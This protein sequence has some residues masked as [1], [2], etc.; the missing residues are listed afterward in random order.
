[1]S[2]HIN[3]QCVKKT[4]IRF[5]VSA[6]HKIKGRVSRRFKDK[7]AAVRYADLLNETGYYEIG[8]WRNYKLFVTERIC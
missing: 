8:L 4:I 2:G 6:R 5:W 3:E 1:M 7:Q